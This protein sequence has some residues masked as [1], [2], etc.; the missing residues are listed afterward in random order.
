MTRKTRNGCRHGAVLDPV[1]DR[2]DGALPAAA[3][4]KE[5]LAR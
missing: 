2:A 3:V 1:R 4:D 5:K